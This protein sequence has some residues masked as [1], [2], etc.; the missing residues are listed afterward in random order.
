M[1]ELKKKYLKANPHLNI[2]VHNYKRINNM[3]QKDKE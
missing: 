2:V 3:L 1:E